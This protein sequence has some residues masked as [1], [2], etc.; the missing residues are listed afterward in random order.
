MT[1][2]TLTEIPPLLIGWICIIALSILL[3]FA[4]TTAQLSK[5]EQLVLGQKQQ[6]R[7]IEQLLLAVQSIE[8]DYT[9]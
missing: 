3:L 8:R 6:L 2:K 7:A 1:Y 4:Q 9:H 5:M